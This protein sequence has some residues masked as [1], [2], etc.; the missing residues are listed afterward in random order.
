MKK[1]ELGQTISILA[2]IGV[3]AGI[4][5]LAIEM[6]Q[7]TASIKGSTYQAMSDVAVNQWQ[8]VS[9]DTMLSVALTK[10]FQGLVQEELSEEENSKLTFF[11]YGMIQRL[12]NTYD[13][14]EAGLVDDRVFKSYGWNYTLFN[15]R[16]FRSYWFRFG[17]RTSTSPEF[18]QFFEEW[19][20]LEP[21][22]ESE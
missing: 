7:N 22:S 20:E 17:S 4:V 5:F 8:G 14:H 10:T 6:R 11:Y 18:R 1:I 12:Q 9:S 2:N 19:F 21:I 15:T 16:H 3:I 13:Q